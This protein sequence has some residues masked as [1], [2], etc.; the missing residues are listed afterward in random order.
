MNTLNNYISEKLFINDNDI[1]SNIEDI[2]VKNILL[3]SLADKRNANIEIC[4]YTGAINIENGVLILD[5]KKFSNINELFKNTNYHIIKCDG[6]Y[7]IDIDDISN[8]KWLDGILLNK[9]TITSGKSGIKLYGLNIDFYKDHIKPPLITFNLGSGKIDLGNN[10]FKISSKDLIISVN[11]IH[12]LTDK[13]FINF[14]SNVK[15]SKT[16]IV[17][18][19]SGIIINESD[20]RSA[21]NINSQSNVLDG[22]KYFQ[23]QIKNNKSL[24]DFFTKYNV[25]M[26]ID[27]LIH[28]LNGNKSKLYNTISF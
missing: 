5:K 18:Y 12:S 23:Y 13:N 24:N 14:L 27:Y 8:V 9:L 11:N 21:L 15:I 10:N 28:Y 20:I 2:A 17:I 26:D 25:S 4:K 6:L 22:K 16:N 19:L 7:L 3:D 1:E